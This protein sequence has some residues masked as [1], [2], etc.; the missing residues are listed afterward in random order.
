MINDCLVKI[1]GIKFNDS[2]KEHD[3]SIIFDK[4]ALV[5]TDERF[6]FTGNLSKVA[7]PGRKEPEDPYDYRRV[8]YIRTFL[9]EL[10]ELFIM[11]I[12]E[13]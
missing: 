1:R 9:Q 4:E 3:D 6:K 5:A 2:K 12:L 11:L 8:L 13:N 10:S 7:E